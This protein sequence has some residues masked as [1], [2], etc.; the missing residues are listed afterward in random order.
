VV[1]PPSVDTLRPFCQADEV[2]APAPFPIGNKQIVDAAAVLVACPAGMVEET[3]SGTWSTVRY[4]RRQ[5]KPVYLVLPDGAV[6]VEG[7]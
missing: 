3:R 2:L 5:G 7:R 4:C 6:R 1:H